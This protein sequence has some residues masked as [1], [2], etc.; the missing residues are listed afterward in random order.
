MNVEHTKPD[1]VYKDICIFKDISNIIVGPNSWIFNSWVFNSLV[2]RE[3]EFR[4]RNEEGKCINKTKV[5][6]FISQ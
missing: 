1:T 2:E 3:M 4:V 6:L 5:T